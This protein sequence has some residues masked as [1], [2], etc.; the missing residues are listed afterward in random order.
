[1]LGTAKRLLGR[2]GGVGVIGLEFNRGVARI[3]TDMILYVS[4]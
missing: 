2:G 1:M 3:A 4:S